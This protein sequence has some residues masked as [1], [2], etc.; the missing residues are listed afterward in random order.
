MLIV[1]WITFFEN[2][3][4]DTVTGFRFCTIDIDMIK[5]TISDKYFIFVNTQTNITVDEKHLSAYSDFV[6]VGLQPA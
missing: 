3:L 4:P 2:Q 5:K 1:V 6:V